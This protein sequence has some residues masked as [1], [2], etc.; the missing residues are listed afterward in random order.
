[1]NPSLQDA[2]WIMSIISSC[3]N[4]FHFEAVDTLIELFEARHKNEPLTTALQLWRM[5]HWNHI[6]TI[7]V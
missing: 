2:N 1:M 3:N 6:H 4:D 5:Q 7:L